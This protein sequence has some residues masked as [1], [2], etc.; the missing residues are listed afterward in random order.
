M[1]C[2]YYDIRTHSDEVYRKGDH[3]I[4]ARWIS[5]REI[6]GGGQNRRIKQSPKPLNLAAIASE[7]C[8]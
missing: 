2:G 5:R 6:F 3:P 8:V 1:L 4:P 7:S